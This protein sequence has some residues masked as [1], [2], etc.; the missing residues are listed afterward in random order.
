M[1]KL[2][3]FIKN[4]LGPNRAFKNAVSTLD[5]V[6]DT[7]EVMT[8]HCL[9]DYWNYHT[10]EAIV[11]KFAKDNMDIKT[12][13]DTYQTDLA[14]FKLGTKLSKY[15]KEKAHFIEIRERARRDQSPLA[16]Y[17]EIYYSRLETVLK[18]NVDA[19]YLAYV[20][21]V[22]KSIATHCRLPSLPALL[23]MIQ[24]GSLKITWMLPIPSALQLQTSIQDSERF[25]QEQ[26]IARIILDDEVLY[27]EG[28]DEVRN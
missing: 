10:V 19:K 18:V 14:G 17:D 22:W 20:D 6:L 13:I 23:D 5:S 7:F 16:R 2:Q 12:L 21:E 15:I 26:K 24:K 8:D 27:D 25:F 4:M 1:K 28:L 3:F 11:N 9:W